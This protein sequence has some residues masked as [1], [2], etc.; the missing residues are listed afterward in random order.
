MSV[1]SPSR[2]FAAVPH[3][4]RRLLTVARPAL[5]INTIGPACVGLWLTGTL[6]DWQALPLIIWL[7]L[8]ANLLIYGLNDIADR[9]TDAHSDRKDSWQGARLQ[10]GDAYAIGW[11]IAL[12]H[13]LLLP[14]V[15][16]YPLSALALMAV[17]LGVFAAYSM[18]PLRLK[19]RP[20]LDSLSNA[21]YAL[22]LAIVPL[23]LGAVPRWDLV[24][25]LMAWSVA[26]HAYDAI[27]DQAEDRRAGLATIATTLGTRGTLIWCAAWWSLASLLFWPTAA[28]LAALNTAYWGYLVGRLAWHPTLTE[29]RRLYRASVLFPYLVG[30]AGGV[31]LALAVATGGWS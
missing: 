6:W 26:K 29:A 28:F 8:P 15:I 31:V 17:Y 7:T 13:L 18:P 30:G 27:Q 5:W 2:L 19:A 1:P 10:A 12:T 21:A 20:F 23:A 25:G 3:I 14:A 9:D 22:P 16:S 11:G 4:L 24:G